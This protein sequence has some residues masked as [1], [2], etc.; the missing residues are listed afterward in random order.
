MSIKEIRTCLRALIK[1]IKCFR[2]NRPEMSMIL[3]VSLKILTLIAE[4]I[5][6]VLGNQINMIR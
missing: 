3:V 2:I 1:L 4:P 6:L 5:I